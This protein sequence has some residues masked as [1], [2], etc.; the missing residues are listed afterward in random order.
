MTMVDLYELNGKKKGEVA[1]PSAVA[2]VKVNPSLVHQAVVRELANC[3]RGTAATKTRG[4]VRGG[5]AKPYRQKGTGRARAGSNRSPLWVGGGTIFGPQPRSY[6]KKMNRKMRKAAIRSIVLDKFNNG[7]L[8]VVESLDLKQPKTKEF[9]QLLTKLK[10]EDSVLIVVVNE[11]TNLTLASRNIKS[12]KL[13]TVGSLNSFDLLKYR[14][15]LVTQP[16]LEMM[17]D[18]QDNAES[19]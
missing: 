10:I 15:L 9:L 1:L 14:L 2:E 19:A 5:G 11:T 18:K 12:V 8:K 16:A 6:E 7:C 17:G 3:R 4:L 13:L